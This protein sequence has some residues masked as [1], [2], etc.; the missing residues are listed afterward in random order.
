MYPTVCSPQLGLNPKS[1]LGGEVFDREILLGI[2]TKNVKVEIILPKGKSHD[3]GIRNWNVTYIPITHLPAFFGNLLYLPYL[4]K[5][6]KKSAFDI[7]RVHQPQYLGL[8]CLIFRLFRKNVKLVAT[9]HQFRETKFGPFSKFVNNNWDH[10][11][12]DSEFVKRELIKNY[13]LAQSKISVVHNGVPSY[14]KPAPKD[15]NLVKKFNLTG[16]VVLLFMGLFIER[17]NP[18]LLLDVLINLSKTNPNTLLIFWGSG[19]LKVQIIKKAKEL[20]V[21]DKIRIIEPIFG[22]EKNKIH[23]LADI[24]VHPSNDEGFALAPLEA[25]TCAKPVVITKGYSAAEAVEDGINGF[26][27]N[28][29][30][31]DNWQQKLSILINDIS[32]RKSMGKASQQ[33]TKKEFQ[34]KLAAE[35][36]FNVIKSLA[37]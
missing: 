8:G 22:S 4:V 23:N 20:G 19:P 27:C 10:I 26:L 13:N 21:F 5:V 18:L 2:A 28:P 15:K 12:C 29:N 14:L 36:H 3:K 17:K 9:Y 34:W 11:I 32:L 30:D 1:I 37:G 31:I 6:Y 16:K 7:L 24:F 25:M 35:I 33:K